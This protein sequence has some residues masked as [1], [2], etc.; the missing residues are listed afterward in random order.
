MRM[1]PYNAPPQAPI[2]YIKPRN[3]W[4]G[5]GQPIA[6]PAS[7][8]RVQVGATLGLVI[9][10]TCVRVREEH[11][12]EHVGGLCVVNDVCLPHAEIFRPAIKERCRD[13]FCPI[14]PPVTLGNRASLGADRAMRTYVGGRLE[15]EWH[16]GELVRPIA[17][18][19]ADVSDFMTL[20][21]GDVL[22][23]GTPRATPLAGIGDLVAV[24]IDGVGR[25]QNELTAEGTAV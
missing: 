5:D 2:L 11:A 15:S 3:T 8:L 6:L 23:L 25:I 20:H 21:P 14:G 4:I 13:G 19:L 22:L 7:T 10:R 9:G 24:E 1:P 16:T 12:G 17:R 18:L